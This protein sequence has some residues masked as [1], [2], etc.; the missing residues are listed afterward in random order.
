MKGMVTPLDI[1][2]EGGNLIIASE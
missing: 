2:E 1:L